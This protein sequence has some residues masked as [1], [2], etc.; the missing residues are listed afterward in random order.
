MQAGRQACFACS[1]ARLYAQ[2]R[3]VP[4][5]VLR[6]ACPFSKARAR[7]HHPVCPPAY[8]TFLNPLGPCLSPK[9]RCGWK[10]LKPEQASSH[11]CRTAG[12]VVEYTVKVH[13]V[14]AKLTLVTFK[15]GEGRL[16]PCLLRCAASL[17]AFLAS[18]RQCSLPALPALRQFPCSANALP[19]LLPPPASARS[20]A[21]VAGVAALH[22]DQLGE[23]GRPPA[24]RG[25]QHR[26]RRR[27]GHRPV[28]GEPHGMGRI[29]PPVFFFGAS[30]LLAAVET[31]REGPS[32]QGPAL[33]AAQGTR[34]RADGSTLP[35]LTAARPRRCASGCCASWPAAACWARRHGSVHGTPHAEAMPRLAPPC[36]A[37]SRSCR[38][39]WLPRASPPPSGGSSTRQS[40]GRSHGSTPWFSTRVSAACRVLTG[41]C[42]CAHWQRRTRDLFRGLN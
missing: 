32:S 5:E 41:A 18:A 19:P 36:R 8:C 38:P 1:A 20:Q 10:T 2:G 9:F 35:P 40:T 22:A 30:V 15:I 37:P 29:V 21:A 31:R 25:H 13:D 34:F 14:P 16:I 7:S 28:D 4:Q 23:P 3:T 17:Q 33:A 26:L 6:F 12:V 27:R 39:S 24:E 42:C 11:N